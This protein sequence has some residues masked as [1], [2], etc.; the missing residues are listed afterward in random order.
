MT[1]TK[2]H[3]VLLGLAIV[4]LLYFVGFTD[5]NRHRIAEWID[6]DGCPKATADEAAADGTP[7]PAPEAAAPVAS[8]P[9]SLT[10]GVAADL[11]TVVETERD[12]LPRVERL[13]RE[14]IW[15]TEHHNAFRAKE[16]RD[17]SRF[18]R[19][20]DICTEGLNEPVLPPVPTFA[21]PA[22]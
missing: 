2:T 16:A 14:N 18:A 15:L 7:A 6:P 5:E 1:L 22:E 13:E 17:R 19:I 20:R 8:A 9:A 10:R 21:D 4:A 12:L 3:L 11:A